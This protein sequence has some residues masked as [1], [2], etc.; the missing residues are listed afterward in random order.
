MKK[1]AVLPKLKSLDYHHYICI[2]IT[3]CFLGCGFIFHNALPRVAESVRDLALSVVYYVFGVIDQPT[4]PIP[5]TVTEMPS[6]Q[7]APERFEPLKLLPYTWE[8]FKVLWGE[9][10]STWVTWDNVEGYLYALSDIF[11]Y[12]SKGLL[13]FLP[14]VLCVWMYSQK[15]IG[16]KNND[17]GKESKQLMRWK[18]FVARFVYPF[19]NRINGFLDF[20]KKNETYKSFWIF[21]WCLYFNVISIFVEAIAFFLYLIVS[22]DIVSL[23]GQFLKLMVDLAPA[24]RFIPGIIWL[25]IG[26][27]VLNIH[28][29]S[30]ALATLRHCENKNRG[31]VNERGVVTIVYGNMGVGKTLQLTSMSLTEEA[32]LRD[33]ALGI[34]QD[35][36]LEFPNFPWDLF[37]EEMKRKMEAHELVD[38]DSIRKWVSS[39]RQDFDWTDEHG[40]GKWY[41]RQIRKRGLKDPTFGYDFIHYATRYNNGL[42]VTRLFSTVEDYACAFYL[43]TI[44][45]SLIISNYAIRSDGIKQDLGNFPVWDYDFFTRDPVLMDEYSRFSHI[46]DFDMLRLGKRMVEEN[47]NRFAFGFG[48]YV[49]SEIDKERKNALELKETKIKEEGCNQRNDLFNQHLKMSRHAVVIRNKVFLKFFVDLQRPEDW[50]AGG[51]DVGELNYIESKEELLPA[52]P[53]YSPF[54]LCEGIYKFFKAKYDE[55]SLRYDVNRADGTLFMHLYKNVM[56]KLDNHY[57]KINNL[58]GCQEIN[59]ELESGRM[60]GNVKKKKYYRMPKKDFSK[61][62]ATNCLSAIF[63]GDEP[64]QISIADLKEYSSIMASSEELALQNSHFQND[65]SKMKK[66]G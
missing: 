1:E 19:L 3:L 9:Y 6:W 49:I 64:N 57:K 10:W 52:L 22:F 42:A 24:V 23:Y 12:L 27:K 53:F 61:R 45:T 20:V 60:D 2:A 58:Y 46:L 39:L 29:R 44:Q 33:D 54:Y 8:E 65:V 18:R 47:P 13:I 66:A 34:I 4:N 43:Y 15:Y 14:L 21:L 37:R 26:F 25:C 48:V 16:T 56:A 36:A 41:Y 28:C 40:C 7:F 32:N 31:Y 5:A 11:Y 63:I 62:Y 51:R 38:V 17:H 50:G 59:L 55:F 35:C 30:Q